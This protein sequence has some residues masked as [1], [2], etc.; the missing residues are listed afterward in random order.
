MNRKKYL[1]RL[2]SKLDYFALLSSYL[3][4]NC[5]YVHTGATLYDLN[6]RETISTTPQEETIKILGTQVVINI[7]S[8]LS[9]Q[10][11]INFCERFLIIN[12]ERKEYD[13]FLVGVAERFFELP[14]KQNVE[15]IISN[16]KAKDSKGSKKTEF[17]LQIV[18]LV[19]VLV[20]LIY[21]RSLNFK[22]LL[23]SKQCYDILRFNGHYL[24]KL[25]SLF[26][27]SN[28]MNLYSFYETDNLNIEFMLK[29]FQLSPGMVF[30]YVD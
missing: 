16:L 1:I 4:K 9:M 10:E 8:A 19:R 2:I 15:I 11:I 14:G 20:R 3:E 7:N 26:P 29:G 6:K 23:P 5:F 21:I 27:F 18:E 30:H 28:K 25:F 12:K 24:S 22:N 17:L 13:V